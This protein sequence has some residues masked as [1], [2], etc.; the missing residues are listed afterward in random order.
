MRNLEL[1][2]LFDEMA[3]RTRLRG[4]DDFRAEAY[5]ATASA[6]R[7]ASKPVSSMLDD[8]T[9]LTSLP[10]IGRSNAGKI[11]EM[12]KTGSCAR[13]DT[14]R[15]DT[16][17]G[18]LPVLRYPDLDAATVRRLWTRASI[19]LVEDLVVALE[20]ERAEVVQ[21][22]GRARVPRLLAMVR[23]RVPD[24]PRRLRHEVLS[25][26]RE[27]GRTLQSCPEVGRSAFTGDVRRC[28]ETVQRIDLLM[29]SEQCAD[30]MQSLSET[31]WVKTVE[32]G[33]EHGFE[34]RAHEGVCLRVRFV[35][36]RHW[37][38]DL[39]LETGSP[40]HLAAL[41]HLP[42]EADEESEVY[43]ALGLPWIPPELRE[44]FGEVEAARAGGL[45]TLV[46]RADLCAD[47]HVHTTASDGT[48]TIEEM[49]RAARER[50]LTVL[51]ITDHSRS[52]VVANG[53][54][55]ERMLRHAD[56]IREVDSRI[57]GITLLAG[58]EV[59]ILADGRLDYPDS[60]LRKLDYV[61]ASV[62]ARLRQPRATATERVCRAIRTGQI[63]AVGHPTG[64]KIDRRDGLDLDLDEVYAACVETG[65]RLE[66]NGQPDRL[67]L[68]WD[69]VREAKAAGVGFVLGSD[70]HSIH[71]LG[72]LELALDV[73]RR[74]GLERGDLLNAFPPDDLLT[75]IQNARR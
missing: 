37:G 73:A 67:D 24:E 75:W 27:I 8:G 43:A 69:R 55:I 3:D 21:L 50:G 11:R 5:R 51:A 9:P 14:L 10:G 45:P 74:G 25:L 19:R 26:L 13:L 65:V 6:L 61:V 4:G 38:R 29:V 42:A 30:T 68:S 56:A 7:A 36:A 41:G 48:A 58:V 70:A 40:A 2:R 34:V 66:I 54:S 60:V 47:L 64:R 18:L 17:D 16:P 46:E 62:H 28:G 49:A 71:S 44:G 20:T 57:Q 12:L 35:E 32:R 1:A 52:T 63:H 23:A 72:Y 39:V 31:G 22:V 15:A 33:D 53:L 59:D